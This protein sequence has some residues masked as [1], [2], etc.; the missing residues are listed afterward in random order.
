MFFIRNLFLNLLSFMCF[1][2]FANLKFFIDRFAPN[3]NACT[4]KISN[5]INSI[6]NNPWS[7]YTTIPIETRERWFQKWAEKF[8]WDRE[9]DIL[10]RK[11]YDH[12]IARRL[13]QMMQDI[14]EGCDN[15]TIW[16]HPNIKKELDVRFSTDEGFKHCHLT[17]RTNRASLRSS[18]YT[19][20]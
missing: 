1:Y 11:I 8:I 16:L 2:V 12:W 13:Q 14:C 3:N 7:S 4:R 10:I 19:G 9:Y 15:L 18:K 20:G 17:S 5:V 6:Y